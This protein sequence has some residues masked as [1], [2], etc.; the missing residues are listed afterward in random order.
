MI[1]MEKPKDKLTIEEL[2]TFC[3]RKGFV[4]KSSDI[5]RGIS[6]FWDFGPLG[7]ELY[8][9]IKADF[10]KFFV[11]DKE[12]MIG[13]DA[14]IISHPKTWEASGHLTAFKDVAVICKKCKKATKVDVSEVKS[15]KLK[16]E[17]GGEY[18]VQG[19]FNLMFKTK[20]GALNPEDIGGSCYQ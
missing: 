13:I 14:S 5:Y 1:C 9:N 17:C 12:N 15:G 11:K 18:E 7:V 16:C 8:N 10:W 3:K 2:T 4:F 6:G 19:E 20:L